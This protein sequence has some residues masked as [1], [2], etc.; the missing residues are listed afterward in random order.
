MRWIWQ[1]A[2]TETEKCTR[3]STRTSWRK[4]STWMTQHRWKITLKA[5]IKT[6]CPPKVILQTSYKRSRENPNLLTAK[7]QL[8]ENDSKELKKLFKL[9]ITVFN[10]HSSHFGSTPRDFRL[11][12]VT[13]RR[14]GRTYRSIGSVCCRETS[15]IATISWLITLKSTDSFLSTHSWRFPW[16]LIQSQDSHFQDIMYVQGGSNMTGTDLCVNKPHYAAAMRPWE[17]EA[18]TSTLPP[19]WVRTCSVLSGSC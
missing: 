12:W 16:T 19:A 2:R 1:V 18:T 15:V 3:G 4:Q 9:E 14:F 10:A 17:S 11:L 5:M 7:H 13:Y 8:A 6:G